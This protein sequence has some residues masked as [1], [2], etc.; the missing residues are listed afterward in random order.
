MYVHR[1]YAE[2]CCLYANLKLNSK[3]NQMN[4]VN[5]RSSDCHFKRFCKYLGLPHGNLAIISRD[6]Q[7]ILGDQAQIKIWEIKSFL[8]S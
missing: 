1:R 7:W 5:Y 6:Y 4:T 2:T 8:G 3:V